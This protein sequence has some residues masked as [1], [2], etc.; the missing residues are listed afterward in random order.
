MH[1]GAGDIGPSGRGAA[2]VGQLEPG[3][4]EKVTQNLNEVAPDLAETVLGFAF[5][6]AAEPAARASGSN[7]G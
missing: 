1:D 4:P 3:A 6:A 7:S 2:G 5:A